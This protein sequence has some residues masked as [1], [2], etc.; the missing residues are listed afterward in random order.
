MCN[1]YQFHYIVREIG[2][3][4][5]IGS[6]DHSLK[7]EEYPK[8]KMRNVKAQT[9]TEYLILF[10]NQAFGGLLPSP[11][12][13]TKSLP[14]SSKVYLSQTFSTKTYLLLI[15]TLISPFENFL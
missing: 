5:G 6:I 1:Y 9:L 4:L 15:F 14:K 7:K 10:W 8:Y 2:L 3:E 11:L 13:L 12:N